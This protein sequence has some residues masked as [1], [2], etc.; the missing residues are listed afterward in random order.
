[1]SADGPDYINDPWAKRFSIGV[2][3]GR[4]SSEM[5]TIWRRESTNA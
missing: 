2:R 3:T 4:G 1:M 5:S